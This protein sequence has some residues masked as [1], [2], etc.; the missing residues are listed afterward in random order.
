[1]KQPLVSCGVYQIDHMC[2][3]R[4]QRAKLIRARLPSHTPNWRKPPLL[5]DIIASHE[6]ASPRRGA[7]ENF[8]E[9]IREAKELILRRFDAA[10]IGRY[11]PELERERPHDLSMY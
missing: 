6:V 5:K 4:A 9:V 11:F 2:V 1:M 8:M 10:I 3:H 7:G